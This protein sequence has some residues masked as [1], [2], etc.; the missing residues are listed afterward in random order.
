MQFT[1]NCLF[2]VCSSR[3]NL[4]PLLSLSCKEKLPISF[5]SPFGTLNIVLFR[6]LSFM[7]IY[8][9]PN[10]ITRELLTMFEALNI[11]H[12]NSVLSQLGDCLISHE[13]SLKFSGVLSRFCTR[14]IFLSSPNKNW[15]YTCNLCSLNDIKL[16]MNSRYLIMLFQLL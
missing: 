5:I 6:A 12:A 11:V 8:S 4:Y 15:F 16:V 3:S 1:H 2:I 13:R 14:L 9:L 10:R 7:R